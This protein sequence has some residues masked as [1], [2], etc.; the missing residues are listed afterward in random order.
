MW[1]Q[2]EIDR[3]P[4]ARQVLAYVN[5]VRDV[6]SDVDHATFTQA[7]V[8]SNDVRCPDAAAA[9]LMYKGAQPMYSP[10]SADVPLLIRTAAN[11]PG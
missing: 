5:R 9:Q 3:C 10:V 8:E 2:R 4:C 7:D 11:D 6:T 1:R